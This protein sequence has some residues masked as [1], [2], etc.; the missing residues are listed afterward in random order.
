MVSKNNLIFLF[1]QLIRFGIIGL[2]AAAVHFGILIALVEIKHFNP[3]VAN[4]FAFFI[5][6]QISYWGHRSWTFYGTTV[7]HRIAFPK[8]LLIGST[9]FA[10][11][12]GLFYIFLTVFNLP[13]PV[14]QFLVLTILPIANFTLG[15][16]WVFR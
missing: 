4:I 6:F 14:A 12:E 10:A 3:L 16:Y 2:C 1:K 9:N 8:L 15:K 5:S 7:S 11:N 13:Y